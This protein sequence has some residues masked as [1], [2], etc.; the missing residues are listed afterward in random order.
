MLQAAVAIIQKPN[1][2]LTA[3]ITIYCFYKQILIDIFEVDAGWVKRWL[4][5]LSML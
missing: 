4:S 1:T 2:I 5:L 3:N